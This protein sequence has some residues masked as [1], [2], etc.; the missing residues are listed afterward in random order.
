MMAKTNLPIQE[1]DPFVTLNEEARKH[2]ENLEGELQRVEGDLKA[3]EELD[4]DTTVL[5]ERV[6]WAKKARRVILDRLSKP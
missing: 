6:E 2:I 4:I 3:M 1:P 5:R